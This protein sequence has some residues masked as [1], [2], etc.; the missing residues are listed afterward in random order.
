MLKK[1]IFNS[2]PSGTVNVGTI[3]K[4][5]NRSANTY[6]KILFGNC[7]K[8]KWF[9]WFRFFKALNEP[10]REIE[11]NP[12]SDGQ[13]DFIGGQR[14]FKGAGRRR[15]S[16]DGD[17]DLNLIGWGTW[18]IEPRRA[19]IWRWL[20]VPIIH[21]GKKFYPLPN[22]RN[23]GPN[24]IRILLTSVSSLFFCPQVAYNERRSSRSVVL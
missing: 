18:N 15:H 19:S 4:E 5:S 12:L 2:I 11:L 8:F 14:S 17:F 9:G 23:C 10:A 21:Y 16:S 20:P 1:I 13:Y 22:P 24:S 7:W 6:V 3:L